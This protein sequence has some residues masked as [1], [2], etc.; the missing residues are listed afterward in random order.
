MRNGT[1]EVRRKLKMGAAAE[2]RTL[3]DYLRCIVERAAERPSGAELR[4]RL[5]SRRGT[6]PEPTPAQVIRSE[7][8]PG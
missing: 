7:R 6:A 1:E 2:G 8:D 4:Q 3:S 5:R